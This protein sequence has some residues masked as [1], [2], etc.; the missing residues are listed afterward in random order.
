MA[1]TIKIWNAASGIIFSGS[2]VALGSGELMSIQE[3]LDN[4]EILTQTD[5]DETDNATQYKTEQLAFEDREVITD[6]YIGSR[7]VT[8][9]YNMQA[10]E[11]NIL[12]E[13]LP[14]KKHAIKGTFSLSRTFTDNSGVFRTEAFKDCLLQ[15]FN[16]TPNGSGNYTVKI[17]FKSLDSRKYITPRGSASYRSL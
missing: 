12:D 9:E 15:S 8:I 3:Q 17:V 7:N 11:N 10:S 16:V 4:G 13:S 1:R 2:G 14:V 5:W 6:R